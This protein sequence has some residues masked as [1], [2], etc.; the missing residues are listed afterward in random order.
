MSG[1][2]WPQLE[3]DS[4]DWGD[5]VTCVNTTEPVLCTITVAETGLSAGRFAAECPG[6]SRLRLALSAGTTAV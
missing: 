2:L 1:P 4:G 6:L 3:I 5:G